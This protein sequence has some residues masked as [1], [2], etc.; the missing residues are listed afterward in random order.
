MKL[1]QLFATVV[2]R[3]P[4]QNTQ[5]AWATAADNYTGFHSCQENRILRLQWIVEDLKFIA[6]ALLSQ[7]FR[8]VLT[9]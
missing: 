7:Q 5:G 3:K 9:V 1:V 6:W 2:S 4:S 8:L